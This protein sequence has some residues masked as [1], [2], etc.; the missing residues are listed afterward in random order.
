M[1]VVAY[2]NFL[3]EELFIECQKNSNDILN[4]K[5]PLT[6]KTNYS[7]GSYLL[8]DS[9]PI[10]IATFTNRNMEQDIAK[11][12]SQKVGHTLKDICYYFLFPGCSIPWHDDTHVNGA[13]SIYLNESWDRN[14]GGL[15]LREINGTMEAV[16]PYRNAALLQTG[17]DY[18]AVSCLTKNAQIRKSIQV[19]F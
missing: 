3:P 10:L 15:Y 14:H 11:Y 12:V 5:T 13:M 9:N 1:P 6:M 4:S 17:G 7:W 18:H 16:I 19:F 8:Q 2:E